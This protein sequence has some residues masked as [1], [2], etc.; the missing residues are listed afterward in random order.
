[1]D[2][3]LALAV[4]LSLLVGFLVGLLAFK[5]KRRW[6]PRCQA[7]TLPMVP[8]QP[9]MKVSRHVRHRRRHGSAAAANTG[10]SA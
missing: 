8:L 5:V 7:L 6:C 4:M 3:R 10:K 9:E 2:L 1:M